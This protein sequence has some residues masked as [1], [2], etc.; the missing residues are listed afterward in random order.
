PVHTAQRSVINRAFTPRAV[1]SMEPV[2]NRITSELLDGAV[3]AGG[4][5]LVGDF[6]YPLPVIVIARILGVAEAR[7]A[8]FKRWSDEI[9]SGI[10]QTP[11]TIP[12]RSQ[13]IDE[14]H[15]YF[16]S[17]IRPLVEQR[18]RGEVLPDNLIGTL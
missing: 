5:D 11:E 17:N 12:I 9:A 16:R 1:A 7:M 18:E 15:D 8:D 14:L 6:A 2:I 13:A 4:F 3:S 10:D